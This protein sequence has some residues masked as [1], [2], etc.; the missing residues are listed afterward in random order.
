M[1]RFD[2][3]PTNNNNL[4]NISSHYLIETDFNNANK[5]YFEYIRD[6]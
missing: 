5:V 3:M 4:Y 2:T 1:Q 6:K